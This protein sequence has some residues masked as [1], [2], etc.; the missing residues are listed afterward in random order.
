MPH[1]QSTYKGN[2][3]YRLARFKPNS[4]HWCRTLSCSWPSSIITRLASTDAGSFFFD[5]VKLKFQP[6]NLFI[7]RRLQPFGR[8]CRGASTATKEFPPSFLELL[9]PLRDLIR[10]H[11]VLPRQLA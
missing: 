1:S 9:L 7:Q 8:T 4:A 3:W 6:T 11:L 2:I 10:V 5:P